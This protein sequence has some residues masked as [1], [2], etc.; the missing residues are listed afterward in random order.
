MCYYSTPHVRLPLVY[1]APNTSPD[2]WSNMDS[3]SLLERLCNIPGIPGFEDDVRAAITEI[4]KPFA[5]R[6]WTVSSIAL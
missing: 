2:D 4:V 3:Y 6:R 5:R 1:N